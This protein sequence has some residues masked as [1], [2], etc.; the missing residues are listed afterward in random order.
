MSTRAEATKYHNAY[1]DGTVRFR[2]VV[3]A[4]Y[5]AA[6][7]AIKSCGYECGNSDDAERFVAMIA[8]YIIESNPL[9]F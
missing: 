7:A 2:L 6:R 1:E 3:D 9:E 5:K 4:A 8:R